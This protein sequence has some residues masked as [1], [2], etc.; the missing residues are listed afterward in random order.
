MSVNNLSFCWNGFVST[1]VD[2]TLAFFPAVFGWS[3]Q[4]APMGDDTSTM[5]ATEAGAVGH[6]RP[7]A[8][9][10]EPSWWNNYLRVEDVDAACEALV[11]QGGSVVVP[12]TDGVRT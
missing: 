7:P 12:R 1:D 2:K 6:V 3:V 9:E 11:G 8:M 5:F 10:Q 4:E